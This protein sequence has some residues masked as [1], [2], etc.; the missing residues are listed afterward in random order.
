MDRIDL[1]KSLNLTEELVTIGRNNRPGTRITPTLITIH[2]TSNA[3]S[4]AD[5]AA[6]SRFI[7]T[8]GYYEHG[9]RKNWVSWHFTVDDLQ[10]IKQIPII[11]MAWHTNRAANSSSLAVEICMHRE[12]DQPAADD[13]AAR[14]VA[15]VLYDLDL[16][17]DAIR[18]HHDWTGKDCPVLLLPRFDSFKQRV[19]EILGSL[20]GPKGGLEFSFDELELAGGIQNL[21]DWEIDHDAVA[22]EVSL[23][24]PLVRNGQ[25]RVDEAVRLHGL[26][27]TYPLGC[28]EFICAVLGIGH[29]QANS[30]M[31]ASPTSLGSRPPYAGLVPGDLVGWKVPSA[32][33]H[34]ALFYG[35]SD[36][37]M[38]IDVRAPGAKPRIKNGFYDREIFKSSRF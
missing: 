5:A 7:R 29:E 20:T 13:R 21:A 32:S 8:K 33:G 9:G 34:I 14:L 36:A 38:F 6:H 26:Q 25:D 31:G 22:G 37:E 17:T 35:K 15:A 18:A 1:G 24:V 11:E 27:N 16:K 30:L 23:E 2:N 4:G 3:R 10:V 19:D 12:I 28:S